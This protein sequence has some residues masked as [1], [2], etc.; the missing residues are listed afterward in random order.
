MSL[1]DEEGRPVHQYLTLLLSNFYIRDTCVRRYCFCSGFSLNGA[2][3]RGDNYLHRSKLRRK[4][5]QIFVQ[6]VSTPQP[7][8]AKK[9]LRFHNQKI[10]VVLSI[11][12]L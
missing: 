6:D 10:I 1:Q 9:A 3:I 7:V 4:S 2:R 12:Y 11:G 8:P 5:N